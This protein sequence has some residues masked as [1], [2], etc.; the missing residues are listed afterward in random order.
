MQQLSSAHELGAGHAGLIVIRA[1]SRG[2]SVG[3]VC[4]LE[5]LQQDAA[6]GPPRG[7]V[8]RRIVAVTLQKSLQ[9]H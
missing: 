8:S 9:H 5:D 2:V 1:T 4:Q 6:Q 3:G 7:M